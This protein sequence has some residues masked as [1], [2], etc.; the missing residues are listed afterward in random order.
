MN[1]RTNIVIIGAGPA[2]LSASIN[3]V[4]RGKSV[5]LLSGGSTYLSRAETVDNYLGFYHTTGAELMQR[6]EEHA[7]QMGIPIEK[8]RVANIMPFGSY[9]MVNFNGD[10]LESDTVILTTGIAKT[11]EIPGEAALLGH[12]VSYCA[13]CD[14][15]LYRGKKAIVWGLSPDAPE[16][17]GFLNGIGVSVTYV[18]RGE[19]PETL[20]D[21]IPF[22]SGTVK[23]II[24]EGRVTAVAAES[25]T[26]P[27][28]GVFILRSS[29]APSAMIAGLELE[30]GYIK[31]NRA[32]ETNIPGLYA[33]GDCTGTPLQVANAVGDGL[34]AAQQAA[35][36]LDSL[37]K[38]E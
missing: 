18:A 5:R 33:A 6:F 20:D 4:A 15:M 17:A 26:L 10:I 9:F 13:T 7:S 19:R 38:T 28:D 35:K 29:I 8:G 11:K 34:I 3:A 37:K 25:E 31:V 32:M 27:A 16:E 30:N 36:Y 14:G 12:G 23:E 21:A 24:G 1:N 2:G 22:V